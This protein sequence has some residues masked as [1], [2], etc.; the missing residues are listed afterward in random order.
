MTPVQIP[1]GAGRIPPLS[2]PCNLAR[3]TGSGAAVAH[4]LWE[5]EVGGS[6]PPSPTNSSAGQGVAA[7]SDS[8]L[9]QPR[10]ATEGAKRSC[11]EPDGQEREW[12]PVFDGCALSSFLVVYNPQ[13]RLSL[14]QVT[15]GS[16]R[17]KRPKYLSLRFQHCRSALVSE[18]FP[19][20]NGSDR[21]GNGPKDAIHD[22][23]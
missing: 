17:T 4:L 6:N 7:V 3:H 11:N 16:Y 15:G 22:G 2:P 20:P 8:P 12:A 14:N 5:Q 13:A 19:V 23:G 21:V 1:A 18:P 9:N 10:G